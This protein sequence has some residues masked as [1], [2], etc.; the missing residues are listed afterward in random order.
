MFLFTFSAI[1]ADGFKTL[2]EG[3]RVTYDTGAGSPEPVPKL[4]P[5]T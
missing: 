1:Q 4:E 3:Q 5:S 2:S